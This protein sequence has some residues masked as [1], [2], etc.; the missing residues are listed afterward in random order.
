MAIQNL[1]TPERAALNPF[2]ASLANTNSADLTA[3][4]AAASDSICRYCGRDFTLQNYSEYYDVGVLQKGIPILLRQFPV[5]S[6]SRVGIANQALQVQNSN[7]SANQRATV[8][9]TSTGLTLFAV[10]SAVSTTTVLPYVQYPTIN[11]LGNAISAVGNG[12]SV[13]IQSGSNGSYGLWPS[14]DLK[15]LQGAVS[16][17]QGG[18]WLE[19]YE[20][21]SVASGPFATTGQWDDGEYGLSNSGPGWRLQGETGELYFKCRRGSLILRIDYVAGYQTVPQSV[22]EAC[23]QLIQWTYQNS[24]INLA[25]KSAAIEA[26]RYTLGDTGKWPTTVMNSLNLVRAY[27]RAAQY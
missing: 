10:A 19:L 18:C 22:Q 25:L 26:Y 21:V 13:A 9:T 4:I 15:P 5:Q 6:I 2:L 3:L 16:A 23:V 8:S 14:A 17:F 1:I 12:W 11:A 20:D 24:T 27:D 7:N